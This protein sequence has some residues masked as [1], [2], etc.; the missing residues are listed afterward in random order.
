MS[1]GD[2][3]KVTRINTQTASQDRANVSH[4]HRKEA[5]SFCLVKIDQMAVKD[6]ERWQ[7]RGR[8]REGERERE[9]GGDGVRKR[10]GDRDRQGM[11]E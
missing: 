3:K 4:K 7:G 9:I 11:R 6:K 2:N 1:N 10:E 5:T 8:W